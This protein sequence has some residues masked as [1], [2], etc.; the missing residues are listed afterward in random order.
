MIA[1]ENEDGSLT[2]LSAT[3]FIVAEYELHVSAPASIAKGEDLDISMS[4]E[5]APDENNCTYGA[6]LIKDQ[7]YKAN[8]KIDSNG[9]K[10]G[11]SVI[12]NEVNLID[13]FDINSSNYRSKLTR[14]ELQTEIQTIIGEG[15]G[16][17]AIGE[18]GQKS[19]VTYSF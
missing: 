9:T 10:N 19:T 12:V 7:A 6:V 16:S 3:A 4:L 13:E 11:T 5:N 2:V 18:K 17:I 1:Q 14:D 15:K 8:I